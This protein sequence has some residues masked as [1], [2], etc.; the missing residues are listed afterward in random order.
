[1]P[2][3]RFKAIGPETTVSEAAAL[4]EQALHRAFGPEAERIYRTLEFRLAELTT[5]DDSQVISALTFLGQVGEDPL[6]RAL[7][8]LWLAKKSVRDPQ[9]QLFL[10]SVRSYPAGQLVADTRAAIQA[11]KAALKAGGNS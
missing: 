5:T 6:L 8:L 1:M 4:F 11:A 7:G 3:Q 2:D 10:E 9:M